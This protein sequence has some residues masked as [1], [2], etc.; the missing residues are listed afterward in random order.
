M[1]SAREPDSDKGLFLYREAALWMLTAGAERRSRGWAVARLAGFIPYVFVD[2]S[3]AIAAGREV[4]GVPKSS[5]GYN[6]QE[7]DLFA[8]EA[9]ALDR[10]SPATP[11]RRSRLLEVRRAAETEPGFAGAGERFRT[12]AGRSETARPGRSP[13]PSGPQT[14][15]NL[16]DYLSDGEIPQMTEVVAREDWPHGHRRALWLTSAGRWRT[17]R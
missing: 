9:V 12:P 5:P 1:A 6:I 7:P 16:A 2:S 15:V 13:A 10:F 8:V 11:G 14:L 3:H 17:R 4:Y